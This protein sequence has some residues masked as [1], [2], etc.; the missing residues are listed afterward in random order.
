MSTNTVKRTPNEEQQMAIYHSGGKLLSAGAGSGKTFVLIEHLIYLLEQIKKTTSITEWNKRI[1]SEISKIVLMTFT[2][3]AAGEMS[4]RMMKKIEE[5]LEESDQDPDELKYWTLVR[6]N[7]S[8]LNITTIHGFCHRLL[9]LGFWNDFPQEMNLV[10]SIEHKDKIQKLFDKWFL[11]NESTLDPIFLASSGA[12]LA[13][14]VEIFSSPE[15]RVLWTNPKLSES[16]ESEIDQ[17]FTQ[18]IEVKGYGSLFLESL[19]LAC[20]EKEKS[21]KW[22]ELLIQFNEMVTVNGSVNSKNYVGF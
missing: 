11:E 20:S 2:K 18:F 9:N 22:Y 12:L 16:A 8:A 15:L 14:M 17:F 3:K 6:Q 7:L 21:K 19:D 4:V 1:A 13:A 5:I 10:S